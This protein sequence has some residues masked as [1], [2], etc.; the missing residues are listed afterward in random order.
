MATLVRITGLRALRRLWQLSMPSCPLWS[1]APDRLRK[2]TIKKRQDDVGEEEEDAFGGD[3]EFDGISGEEGEFTV[4]D[5]EA[6]D[7]V[8]T[9]E[10]TTESEIYVG[11]GYVATP[12]VAARTRSSVIKPTT[13]APAIGAAP[14]EQAGEEEDSNP[15][16][17]FMAAASIASP[18]ASESAKD[19]SRKR[20][21]SETSEVSRVMKLTVP[22]TPNLRVLKRTR[23]ERILSSTSLELQK[24]QA[25]RE[26]MKKQ[27]EKFQKTY[28]NVKSSAA[29]NAAP[30]SVKPLTQVRRFAQMSFYRS[31][32]D[33]RLCSF[34]VSC[35]S[36]WK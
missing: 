22:N 18:G 10:V 3:D 30:R 8:E 13:P 5:D 4:S 17:T 24:I 6:G 29:P 19:V 15:T 28:D 23:S 33:R 34:V 31:V 21:P 27:K 36:L 35:H 20:K 16:S 7:D 14:T 26:A 2:S 12:G 32:P 25:E 1:S 9:T 11:V